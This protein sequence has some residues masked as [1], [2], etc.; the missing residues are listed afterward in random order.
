M[1]LGGRGR[2]TMGEGMSPVISLRFSVTRK[3]DYCMP[4]LSFKDSR[5]HGIVAHMKS[6]GVRSVQDSSGNAGNRGR[7]LWGARA[8]ISARSTAA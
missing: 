2:V 7:G 5:E 8:G 4:T 1:A 6:I 3:M